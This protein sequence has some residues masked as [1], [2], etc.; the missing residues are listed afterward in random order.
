MEIYE[1]EREMGLKRIF[2]GYCQLLLN[3]IYGTNEGFLGFG[4]TEMRISELYSES[5]N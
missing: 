2:L 1:D 3:E 5:V 4:D